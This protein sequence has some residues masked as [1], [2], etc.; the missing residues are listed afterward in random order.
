MRDDFEKLGGTMMLEKYIY[1]E[2]NGL[3]YELGEDEIYYPLLEVPK[4]TNY[5]IGKYERMRKRYLEEYRAPLFTSL[6]MSGKLNEH[7]HEIDEQ[8]QAIIEQTVAAMATANGCDDTLKM[9]DQMKWVG[10]MN[11]YKACAEEIVFK[12]LIYV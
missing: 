12:E 11:N 10:L 1:D 6:L 4:S 7:L 8:A 3:H 9:Q 5:P 2:Q